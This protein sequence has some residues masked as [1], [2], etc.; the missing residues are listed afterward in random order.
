MNGSALKSSLATLRGH[1]RRL[2]RKPVRELFKADRNRYE[3]HSVWLEGMV[4]DHSRQH[5]DA[6]ALDAL[7]AVAAASGVE[8]QRERMFA[9]AAVNTT[10]GR[11]AL[12]TALRDPAGAPLIVEGEDIRPGIAQTLQAMTRF[13][14]ALRAGR[15]A[16]A[17]RKITDVV[18]IGI[19][20]SGLGPQMTVRALAPFHNGPRCHFVSNVDGAALADAL[21]GLDPQTTQFLVAS[22]TFTTQETMRNAETARRWVTRAVGRQAAGG[23]FCAIT[24]SPSAAAKFGIAAEHVF[25]FGD[26]V[27]GR[28]SIWSSVGLA[29]MLAIGP[30]RFGEFL[31]GARAADLHFRE[32]P[33]AGNIPVL[34]AMLGIWN[35]NVHERPA[36]AVLPYDERLCHLPAYLQQLEMESNGKSVTVSGKPVKTATAPVVWGTPGTDGQHAY[37]QLLHQGTGIV[38]ADFLVAANPHERNRD[39]HDI[40]LANCLAQAE[41]LME[42]LEEG[43]VRARLEAAGMAP[44]EARRLAPH[45][46]FSGN[47]P[48]SLFLYPRLDPYRL[49]M[50]IAL[51]EHKVFVQGVVW[52]INSF[53]QWGVELGKKLAGDL[54]PQL[55][56]SVKVGATGATGGLIRAIERMRTS[57]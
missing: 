51:Y 13:A 2:S 23:H 9:G 1:A 37:F 30:K 22:K 24:A 34:M 57:R 26:W 55:Q 27:G 39:H 3:R 40:L 16:P 36:H 7:L 38:P 53:D 32:T 5:V 56:G 47:R 25:T 43:E 14:N 44:A 28:Y 20:G 35:I 48:S 33:L 18:N 8:T 15:H 41:A 49:G 19:G 45:R 10:E 31:D 46:A 50:L 11:A 17:G 42:G 6:A 54:L 52:G 4:F 21:A 12:H 29:L